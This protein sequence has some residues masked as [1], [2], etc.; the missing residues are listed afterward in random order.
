[1]QPLSHMISIDR[2]APVDFFR[3]IYM[4]SEPLEEGWI[5]IG[6]ICVYVNIIV[7]LSGSRIL[8]VYVATC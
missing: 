5:P 3:N 6:H 4:L 2:S 1:M 7:L 8:M